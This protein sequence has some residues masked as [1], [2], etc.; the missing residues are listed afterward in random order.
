M[1]SAVSAAL[2]C[3]SPE[4]DTRFAGVPTAAIRREL[5]RRKLASRSRDVRANPGN[6]SGT[7]KTAGECA[8]AVRRQ[9]LAYGR[10]TGADGDADA[11]AGLA[12]LHAVVEEA[13]GIACR[14]LTRP[15]R[16]SWAEVAARLDL[17]KQA[18]WDRYHAA[19]GTRRKRG[20]QLRE[21]EVTA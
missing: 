6:I 8:E 9:I 2:T 4:P 11:L 21:R 18:A 15:G 7:Y 1:L 3:S 14:D 16:Y 10:R 19:D 13:V 12:A 17:G 5:R 20:T